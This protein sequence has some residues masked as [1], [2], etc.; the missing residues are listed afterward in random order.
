MVENVWHFSIFHVSPG[1]IDAYL[2]KMV[3]IQPEEIKAYPSSAYI[4]ASRAIER[5][6]TRIRPKAFISNA[7]TLTFLQREAIEAAFGCKVADQ[8][9]SAEVPFWV[10][11]CPQGTYHINHEFGILEAVHGSQPVRGEMGDVVGTGFVNRVQYLIRYR[12]G[13]SVVLPAH[14][15]RCGCGWDTDTVEQIEG[16]TDDVLYSPDGRAFG[17]LDIILK[18]IPGVLESQI[19]QDAHDHLTI[20]MVGLAGPSREAEEMISQRLRR[21]FGPVIRLDFNWM[22]AIPRGPNGK[23]R[24]QLN[25]LPR[26][27]RIAHPEHAP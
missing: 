3:A 15:R 21:C 10:G 19:V 27:G 24:Y 25:R 12:L 8:Y 26:T 18:A 1:T 20:N 2:D 23:F 16:R 17:R 14:E 22:P 7:E 5:K 13:D 9:G 6:E 4:L 11:Q